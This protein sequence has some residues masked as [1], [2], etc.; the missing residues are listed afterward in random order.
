VQNGEKEGPISANNCFKVARRPWTFLSPAYRMTLAKANRGSA[1][2]GYVSL[3]HV[4]KHVTTPLTFFFNFLLFAT[5]LTKCAAHFF[6]IYNI[7]P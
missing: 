1:G 2:I 4:H 5:R 6:E 3:Y 7:R